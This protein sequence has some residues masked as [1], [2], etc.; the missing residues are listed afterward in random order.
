MDS[1]CD[2]NLKV[3]IL[4]ET[5]AKITIP[6]EGGVVMFPSVVSRRIFLTL[7]REGIFSKNEVKDVLHNRLIFIGEE[8]YKSVV[9]GIYFPDHVPSPE[10]LGYAMKHSLTNEQ[11]SLMV[12]DHG[13]TKEEY[14]RKAEGFLDTIFGNVIKPIPEES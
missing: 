3:Q 10:S 9:N 14:I 12:F 7:Y 11:I 8:S 2:T 5:V 13:E 1:Q 6:W 4:A